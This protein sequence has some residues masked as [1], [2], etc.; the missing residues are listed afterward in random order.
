MGLVVRGPK[1]GVKHGQKRIEG[2]RPL[3]GRRKRRCTETE[4]NWSTAS[5]PFV[6]FAISHCIK[7]ERWPS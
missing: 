7:E 2:P 6:P 4:A 1:G 3:L 5:I